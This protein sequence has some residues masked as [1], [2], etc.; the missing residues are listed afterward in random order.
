MADERAAQEATAN[1]LSAHGGF[2]YA[3]TV[4]MHLIAQAIE[5]G[6]IAALRDMRDGGIQL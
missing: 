3:P 4:M 1:L 5:T 6:Y 2:L